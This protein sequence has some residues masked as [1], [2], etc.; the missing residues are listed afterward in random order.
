MASGQT[1]NYGLNQW[2]SE[3]AVL[4]EEFNR[5]NAKIEVV[6]EEKCYVNL[7][8]T[9]VET[10]ECNEISLETMATDLT[11][12]WKLD[13]FI[14]VPSGK[15]GFKIQVN[16]SER[17]LY[18][19]PAQNAGGSTNNMST[20]TALAVIEAAAEH[21]PTFSI[22]LHQPG[23]HRPVGCNYT[24]SYLQ[25]DTWRISSGISICQNVTWD[26]VTSFNLISYT[27]TLELGTT[28]AL[29]GVKRQ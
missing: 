20:T 3:D 17:Y 12:Y 11:Q 25:N 4:R 16:H 19:T 18:G 7:G 10:P 28:L 6:F 9:V 23:I 2:T 29:C 1:T 5:D 21:I 26:Q 27:G 13:L 8:K 24:Y 22:T 14:H 15:G